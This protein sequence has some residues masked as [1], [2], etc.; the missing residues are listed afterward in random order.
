V[1]QF[2]QAILYVFFYLV[3]YH[4]THQ[5]LKL[6][7]LLAD[8][9]VSQAAR[10]A[11]LISSDIWAKKRVLMF[12]WKTTPLLAFYLDLFLSI[13]ARSSAGAK[14]YRITR[15]TLDIEAYEKYWSYVTWGCWRG[16]IYNP[17]VAHLTSCWT[18]VPNP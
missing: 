14:H 12:T 10:C 5:Y 3:I 11:S 17:L 1:G 7:G 16:Q 2:S 8:L 15:V 4:V 6:Q 9:Q 18:L 13:P